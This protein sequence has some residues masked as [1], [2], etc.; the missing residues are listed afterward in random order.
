MRAG[1]RGPESPPRCRDDAHAH[2][3][4]VRST[5]DDCPLTAGVVPPLRGGRKT[6]A[7][8]QCEMLAE[9]TERLTQ[10]DVLFLSWLRRQPRPDEFTQAET[11]S[12]RAEFFSK[13][14]P[15]LRTSPLP[16]TYGFGLLFDADGVVSLCP[17]ESEE[18]QC[19]VGDAGDI[20]V[21]LAMRS[22]RRR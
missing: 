11:A 14:Q 12:L 22:A 2:G 9:G 15:C 13:D 17:M 19:I 20:R 10:E 7:V 5:A 8:Q 18:Y 16:K 3:S 1:P 4:R 6:V 21:V